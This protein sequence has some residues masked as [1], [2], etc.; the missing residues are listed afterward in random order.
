M[1]EKTTVMDGQTM[2]DICLQGTG[3]VSGIFELAMLNG[4]SVTDLPEAGERLQR[5]GEKARGRLGDEK[6]FNYYR[7][8]NIRPVTRVEVV[9]TNETLFDAGLFDPGLFD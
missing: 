8:N 2:A 5:L 3:S 1:V 6:I 4:R 9:E 7:A